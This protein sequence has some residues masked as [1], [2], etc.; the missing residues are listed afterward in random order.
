MC[1][2]LLRRIEGNDAGADTCH[3]IGVNQIF[4]F[5]KAHELRKDYLCYDTTTF[6]YGRVVLQPCSINNTHPL[7]QQWDYDSIVQFFFF[8]F[9]LIL[10]LIHHNEYLLLDAYGR[11]STFAT[12]RAAPVCRLMAS[13]QSF[14]SRPPATRT[15]RFNSGHSACHSCSRTNR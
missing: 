11:T 5:S 2:D 10:Q 14:S 7:S 9:F 1:L 8:F 4:Q 13:T 3:Q 6:T 15:T 12:E